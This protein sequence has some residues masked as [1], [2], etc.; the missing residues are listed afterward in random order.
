MS[1]MF[2]IIG[3]WFGLALGL[4]MPTVLFLL[5]FTHLGD[6]PASRTLSPVEQFVTDEAARLVAESATKALS[7]VSNL[8]FP[9]T[10]LVGAM[11]CVAVLIV[12]VLSKPGDRS[13]MEIFGGARRLFDEQSGGL[14]LPSLLSAALF[15]LALSVVTGF[16]AEASQVTGLLYLL[17]LDVSKAV[18]EVFPI[19][20]ASFSI[21]AVVQLFYEKNRMVVGLDEYLQVLTA[22]L[23]ELKREGGE[24][25]IA[26]PWL[27]TGALSANSVLF[28]A[29]KQA[30]VD[31]FTDSSILSTAISRPIDPSMVGFPLLVEQ[32]MRLDAHRPADGSALKESDLLTNFVIVLTRS[33]YVLFI[34]LHGA[35][36]KGDL[37]GDFLAAR[38]VDADAVQRFRKFFDEMFDEPSAPSGAPSAASHANHVAPAP[39]VARESQGAP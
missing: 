2:R 38:I 29:F 15:F 17:Q 27:A 21:L 33:V 5:S 23:R 32:Q 3:Y 19:Y 25:R 36:R 14:L 13:T 4:L 30:L 6:A 34:D 22:D 16:D 11:I 20:L 28:N 35:K 26:V 8:A 1:V 31:C 7:P 9:L 18:R 24:L 12:Y 10:F 39:G 37:R